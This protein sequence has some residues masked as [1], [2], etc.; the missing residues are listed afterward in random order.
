VTDSNRVW[1]GI[2]S[3]FRLGDNIAMDVAYNHALFQKGKIAR[4]DVLEAGAAT[5]LVNADIIS[6]ID[7]VAVGIR[8]TFD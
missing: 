2:G 8:W 5:V 6:S 1:L 7:T 4:T 3:T